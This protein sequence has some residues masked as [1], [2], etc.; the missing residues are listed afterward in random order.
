M[1]EKVCIENLCALIRIAYHLT[2]DENAWAAPGRIYILPQ[3]VCA[4]ATW[5][6]CRTHY[7]QALQPW[8]C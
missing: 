7:S 8:K 5:G 3:S 1:K 4:A 2:L 6:S